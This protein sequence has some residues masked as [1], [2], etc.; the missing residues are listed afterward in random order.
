MDIEKFKELLD[1]FNEDISLPPEAKD[2]I[3]SILDI[4]IKI[5]NNTW[6]YDLSNM[7]RRRL[8]GSGTRRYEF[9]E[10]TSDLASVNPKYFPLGF[11]AD[12]LK[13]QI[14]DIEF[15]RNFIQKLRSLERIMSDAFLTRSDEAY[16]QSLSFY[17]YVRVLT[18]AGN[19]EA[20]AI[21]LKLEPFFSR[22]RREGD[23]PSDQEIERDVNDLLQGKKEGEI[24]IK[25]NC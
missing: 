25:G 23:E 12:V 22:P 8:L 9:I 18:H 4:S 21:Y 10:K 16:H 14:R 20:S 5:F 19:P 2:F 6:N 1:G 17:K 24:L 7:D 13:I 11:D 15:F 3:L